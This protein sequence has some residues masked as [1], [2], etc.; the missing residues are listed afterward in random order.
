VAADEVTD[1]TLLVAEGAGAEFANQN[2]RT[3]N[4]K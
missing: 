3:A 1:Q 4:K 2:L